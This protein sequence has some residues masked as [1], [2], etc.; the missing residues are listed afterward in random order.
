MPSKHNFNRAQMT[1]LVIGALGVI[2]SLIVA[3]SGGG[4][5]FESYLYSF[6]FWTG[7][8]LGC[9]MMIAVI[10]MA[11]GSWGA[12]ILR[13]LE[14]GVA[15]L[16]VMGLL[17]IP[18]LFGLTSL[19]EWTNPAYVDAHQLV[20][21]K[22]S[23]LNLP[24][25]IIRNILYFVIWTWGALV[26][27]RG[28]NKQDSDV[29]ESGSIA[30]RLRRRG[31]VWIFIYVMTMTFAGIDWGMSLTPEWF[32]GIY[33]VILMSGQ[34]ISAMAFIIAVIVLLAL[35]SP[36]VNELLTAKRL[37][38]LGNFLM[39]FMMFW[40][41]VHVSQLMILWSN[42]TT[43]TS[44]YYVAR[45]GGAWEYVAM[46]LTAFGFFAPF[47]I[48]FSRWV[49]QKRAALF[50]VAIW[51][52]L[53]RVLDLYWIIIPSFDRVGAQF[54]VTDLLLLIGLG[55]IWLGMYLRTLAARPLV[56]LHDPRLVEAVKQNA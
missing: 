39:A 9:L 20:S 28:G 15:V 32:S 52:I 3:L 51:A 12:L 30:F 56:P 27:L 17:F 6:I 29:A 2:A 10:H 36:R 8:S 31:P 34:V 19:Y 43:E 45:L 40:A 7:L 38:D 16:P 37:Q 1:A 24:F 13:P 47:A 4:S 53:V 41:Y 11:G 42:N 22:S 18:L 49:K 48:L 55:G 54:Q 14:A 21:A 35:V 25:F 33:S 23:Y 46:F 44:G 5:F 50:I 26:F